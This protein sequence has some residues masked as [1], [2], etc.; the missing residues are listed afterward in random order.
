M[1]ENNIF[2]SDCIKGS[3]KHIEEK[4]IDL[5]ICDPPF[6]IN[7]N[8]FGKH[9]NRDESNVIEGY[10]EAPKNYVEWTEQ[11]LQEAYRILKDNGSIYVISG[12][13]NAHKIALAAENVGFNIV[14]KI[15]WKFNFG[16]ATKQKYVSSHYEIFYMTKNKNA[17]VTFNRCCRF[18]PDDKNDNNGSLLYQDLEDVWTINKEN[19]PGK[20]KNKNKLP[21]DLIRKIIQYSSNE[22][23]IICDFFLG[24]FTTAIVAK[25]MGRIPCGFEMNKNAFRLNIKNLQNVSF[26][27]DLDKYSNKS[28]C[29]PKNQGKKIIDKTKEVIITIFIQLIKDGNTKKDVIKKLSKRFKRGIFSI[30]NIVK[31]IDINLVKKQKKNEEDID[32]FSRTD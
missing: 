31:E 1:K 29:A 9:Y 8:T 2:N 23:D 5:M 14:N 12:W 19:C 18:T 32:L 17:D 13:T 16:V 11:W 25:K 22:N 27:E 26:G 15:I 28:Y 7:E 24:N 4:S 30:T 10:I 3:K 21:E 6:G 20:K